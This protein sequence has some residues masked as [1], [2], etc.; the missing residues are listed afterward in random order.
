MLLLTMDCTAHHVNKDLG[1]STRVYDFF[2]RVD[3]LQRKMERFKISYKN[4]TDNIDLR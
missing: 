2:L 4:G 3:L 1:I